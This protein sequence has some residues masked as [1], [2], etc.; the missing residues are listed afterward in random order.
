MS[1]FKTI[2]KMKKQLEGEQNMTKEERIINV[3]KEAAKAYRELAA[4]KHAGLFADNSMSGAE[5]AGRVEFGIK[6]LLPAYLEAYGQYAKGWVPVVKQNQ[7]YILYP[8]LVLSILMKAILMGLDK[9]ELKN[10]PVIGR[11]PW[12]ENINYLGHKASDFLKQFVNETNGT[13]V[14]LSLS[15][16]A[17]PDELRALLLHSSFAI[18]QQQVKEADIFLM[19]IIDWSLS[20]TEFLSC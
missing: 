1:I 5:F 12:D 9:I 13:D 2:E 7:L 16:E 8:E 11:L 14:C 6:P 20:R 4:E 19:N 17:L 10:Y 18:N 15:S 3:R